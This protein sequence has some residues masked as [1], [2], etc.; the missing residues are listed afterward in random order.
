[1]SQSAVETP[2]SPSASLPAKVQDWRRLVDRPVDTSDELL[3]NLQAL[4]AAVYGSDFSGFEVDAVQSDAHLLT[5]ELFDLRLSI[6]DRLPEWHA[7]GLMHPDTARAARNA[8]RVLRYTADIVGE[9]ASR[10]QRLPAGDDT[11]KAFQGPPSWTQAHPARK[12]GERLYFRAGDVLLVRGRLHNSAAIA[13]IGDVDSQFSHVGMVHIAEDGSRWL[14]E[15][16]I[17]EG[18]TITALDDALEHGLG[19]ALLLRYRDRQ[20]AARASSAMFDRV[21]VS[22]GL[23]GRWI[24]YDFTMQLEGDDELYCSKLIRQAYRAASDGELQLPTHKTRLDMRNRDFFDRIGVT[25]SETFAPAD[26]EV[27]PGFDV[28]AEWRDYRVTSSLRLQDLIMS[29]LFDWMDEHDYR[30]QPDF[31]IAAMSLL[32]RVSGWLPSTVKQALTRLGVPKIPSN[33]TT[34]TIGAI[35][36]LHK[37]AQP[38]LEHLEALEV[39]SIEASGRPLHPHEV[40]IE[41]EA[42]RARSSNRIGYLVR[43]S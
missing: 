18:A 34:S 41:L 6:R 32:G 17:E 36:M 14:V 39:R 10:F 4:Y 27:E 37:T 1:M 29:K 23:M 30:F 13:R 42:Y 11:Y 33:M 43:Q 26:L 38:I 12:L 8:I 24:P 15:A 3:A 22:R 2:S 19:R 40:F 16:L 35:A 7:K 21:A 25:A 28:V 31:G 5:E 20:L 9:V